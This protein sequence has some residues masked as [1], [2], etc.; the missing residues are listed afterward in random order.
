MWTLWPVGGPSQYGSD[1]F[2]PKENI[3]GT[4]PILEGPK[5]HSEDYFS[6]QKKK[7]TDWVDYPFLNDTH[8]K[9]IKIVYIYLLDNILFMSQDGD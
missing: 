5:E 2:G 8:S 9:K 3:G 4:N 6:Q 7:T 1:I